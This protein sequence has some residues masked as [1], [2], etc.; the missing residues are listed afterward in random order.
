MLARLSSLRRLLLLA[1]CAAAMPGYTPPPFKEKSK[2]AQRWRA[3]MW[4]DGQYQMADQEKPMD[5]KRTTGSMMVVIERLKYAAGRPAPRSW[6]GAQRWPPALPR[7]SEMGPDREAV[8][9]RARQ[10]GSLQ[11]QL[12]AKGCKT[13]NIEAELARAPEPMDKKYSRAALLT[14]AGNS[15]L[16]GPPPT[17][18]RR[19]TYSR[20]YNRCV[21]AFG[22]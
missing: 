12:A 11:R 17:K 9:A 16:F 22:D 14:A 1:A 10:A 15:A 6:P 20:I 19:P 5:C 4:V 13:L 2:D 8:S 21:V 18:P 3:A 7:P